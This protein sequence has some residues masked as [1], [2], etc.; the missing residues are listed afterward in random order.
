MKMVNITLSM[1]NERSRVFL[2]VQYKMGY[3]EKWVL[4][5]VTFFSKAITS[6]FD[7]YKKGADVGHE[8]NKAGNMYLTLFSIGSSNACS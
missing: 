4:C 3:E 7:N 6:L 2:T 8:M 1:K 5:N